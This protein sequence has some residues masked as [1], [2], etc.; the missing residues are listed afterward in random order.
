[1]ENTLAS[2][3]KSEMRKVISRKSRIQQACEKT[4]GPGYQQPEAKGTEVKDPAKCCLQETCLKH[5][6]TECL[7]IK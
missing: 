5:K 1:M 7:A 2:G 3:D 4:E 6:D